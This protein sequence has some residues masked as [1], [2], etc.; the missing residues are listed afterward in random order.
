MLAVP[1]D[2]TKG[3]VPQFRVLQQ[4]ESRQVAEAQ[5]RAVGGY[6]RGP[7]TRVLTYRARP[8]RL[9]RTIPRDRGVFPAFP[10]LR[11]VAPPYLARSPPTND[12]ARDLH[13][14]RA[15]ERD[16]LACNAGG[17]DG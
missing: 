15:S 2:A 8:P 10:H 5:K 17:C 1:L 4:G 13:N 11:T 14:G 9:A 7:R 12:L 6:A 3:A 16:R